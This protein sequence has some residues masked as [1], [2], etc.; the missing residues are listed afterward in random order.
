ML[1]KLKKIADLLPDGLSESAIEE[2]VSLCQETVEAEVAKEMKV[3]ES[4]VDG[5]LRSK[6]SSLKEA[7]RK[8][9]EADSKLVREA[10]KY[11]MLRQLIAEDV[12]TEDIDS[13]LSESQ[14]KVADLESNIEELNN[15]LDNALRENR[16][17]NDK[18][19]TLK[20]ENAKLTERSKLPAKLKESAVV[21]TNNTDEPGADTNDSG[22][23][24]NPFLSEHTINLALGK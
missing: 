14:A 5:F 4:K 15:K 1:D 17:L 19:T 20:E 16:M 22:D 21:I 10:R 12:E 9:L 3:L 13:A 24:G 18:Q 2:V 8:D 23:S 6:M 7:A 11:R